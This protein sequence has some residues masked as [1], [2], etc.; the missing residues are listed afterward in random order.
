MGFETK[1][2]NN[3]IGLDFTYYNQISKD[4]IMG[5]ASSWATGYPYR[6]INA[7]E[8][9]NQGIEIALN[10]RPIIIGDFSWDL[11]I[12][13]S[14]NNNKVRKLV[15]GMDMF[16]L[17]KA[18]WLD[19]QVAAKVGENFGSIVGPDFQR[20]E[21]GDILIGPA[22]GLPMYDKSN[23]VL[24]NAS[25]D[26]TGGLS[27]TFVYKN[28]GLTALFDVKVGADLYSMSA[29]AAH[30]SGKEPF[31]TLAGREEWYKSEEER[32]AAGIAKVPRHGL[33]PAVLSHPV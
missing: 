24:G 7:G 5:M 17:E 27:T 6:L 19:V 25:W 9:Q 16:E 31:A 26:W 4:Q 21:N 11:G 15:D 2:L 13:F 29:R 12:N 1:F 10:T 32:Q 3:R 23:H 14:K 22:T 18:S 33:Q 30:E 8:I 28:F 20:N